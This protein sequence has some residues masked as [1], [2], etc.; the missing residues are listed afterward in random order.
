LGPDSGEYK[1]PA[2]VEN[3]IPVFHTVANH[4]AEL[5]RL[6]INI[7]RRTK[8][9][10]FIHP[11]G[12]ETSIHSHG[13]TQFYGTETLAVGRSNITLSDNRCKC[14]YTEVL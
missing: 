1:S 3:R 2:S 13:E 7:Y 12:R 9:N 14:T 8:P 4:F 11:D 5:S 6:E 10:P